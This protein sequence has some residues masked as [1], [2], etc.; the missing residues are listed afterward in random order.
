MVSK[1]KGPVFIADDNSLHK[2]EASAIQ[3]DLWNE[4]SLDLDDTIKHWKKMQ[5]HDILNWITSN[6]EKVKTFIESSEQMMKD[7]FNVQ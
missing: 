3:H 1:Y 7:V 2:S 5:S 4:L 6:K